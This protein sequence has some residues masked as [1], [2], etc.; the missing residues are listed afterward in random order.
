MLFSIESSFENKLSRISNKMILKVVD[1]SSI[2]KDEGH[3]D[4]YGEF[5]SGAEGV[6]TLG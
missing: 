4:G 3:N 2:G 6:T 1:L 5:D